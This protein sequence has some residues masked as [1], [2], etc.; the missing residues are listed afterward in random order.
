MSANTR[1]A[2]ATHLMMALALSEG[3]EP[4]SSA[5]L[6][7]SVNSSPIVLRR[8][9]AQLGAAGLVVARVGR[10][11]GSALARPAEAITLLDIHRAV[12]EPG[13]FALCGNE[14]N[15]QCPVGACVTELLER[16]LRGVDDAV[17][18]ELAKT[19]LSDLVREIAARPA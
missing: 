13:V 3:R 4:L 12:D 19:R 7:G 14:P 6:A 18:A 10:G 2:V 1:F 9:L 5:L 15:A 8:L 17:A 16:V 11:G